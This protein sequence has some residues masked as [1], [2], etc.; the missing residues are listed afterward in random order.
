MLLDRWWTWKQLFICLKRFSFISIQFL[1]TNEILIANCVEQ[2]AEIKWTIMWRIKEIKNWLISLM[3]NIDNNYCMFIERFRIKEKW[4]LQW[5][6]DFLL[7]RWH[8]KL[9]LHASLNFYWRLLWRLAW[10]CCLLLSSVITNLIGKL[11]DSVENISRSYLEAARNRVL[12]LLIQKGIMMLCLN[13]LVI[14]SWVFEENL[15][16]FYAPVDCN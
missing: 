4:K 14:I 2:N 1:A 11:T 5:N 16:S 7:C 12:Q 6:E 13:L 8:N 9:H 10:I 3:I 15:V